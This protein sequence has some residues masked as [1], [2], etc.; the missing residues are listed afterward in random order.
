MNEKQQKLVKLREIKKQ[1]GVTEM[2]I[3]HHTVALLDEELNVI[4][5]DRQNQ[6]L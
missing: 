1:N 5:V 3:M 2:N 4:S 6:N